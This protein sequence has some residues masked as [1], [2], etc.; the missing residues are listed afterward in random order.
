MKLVIDSS[1]IIKWL[2]TTDEQNIEKADK[3]LSDSL[4][5][6]VELLAPEL[7]KYEIGNVLLK[8]KQLT[9]HQAHISLGTVYS[10]PIT[11]VV[12]SEDLA[13][14]TY[15]L[16]TQGTITYYDAAFLSLAKAYGATLVTENI[17]HQ[18]KS[19]DIKVIEL[20]DY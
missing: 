19:P 4:Q 11:F 17:K 9:T 15:Y 18:G 1:V 8:S 20:K 2:N 10:L 14:E 12:E 13:R 5:G 6:N 16:A 3:I 7:A